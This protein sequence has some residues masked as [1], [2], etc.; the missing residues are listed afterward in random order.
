MARYDKHAHL[1]DGAPPLHLALSSERRAWHPGFARRC[2]I[3]RALPA[4]L[5]IVYILT[6]CFRVDKLD[7]ACRKRPERANATMWYT[8]ESLG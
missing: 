7:L 3:W 5:R 2:R 4:G 8:E 1:P 6:R